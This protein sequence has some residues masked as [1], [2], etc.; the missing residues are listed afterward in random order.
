MRRPGLPAMSAA[1]LPELAAIRLSYYKEPWP[2]W[3]L[4]TVHSLVGRDAAEGQRRAGHRAAL[5]VD[6][7]AGGRRPGPSD[8]FPNA[9][10]HP[11]PATNAIRAAARAADCL[12][13][14]TRILAPASR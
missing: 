8:A 13:R 2:C 5:T 7:H 4:R 6:T 12:S 1:G 11:R 14:S 9:C 10:R 3:R